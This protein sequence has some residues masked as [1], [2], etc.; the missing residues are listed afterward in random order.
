M[1]TQSLPLPTLSAA[2]TIHVVFVGVPQEAIVIDNIVAE[3]PGVYE[4]R[5]WGRAWIFTPSADGTF[6]MNLR[7]NLTYAFHN[8]SAEFAQGLWGIANDSSRSNGPTSYLQQYDSDSGLNRLASNPEV[9]TIHVSPVERWIIDHRDEYELGFAEPSY[10]VFLLDAYSTGYLPRD[11]YHYWEYPVITWG[12]G[13]KRTDMR[14]WGGN[15]TFMFLDLSAAPSDKE[16]GETAMVD[17]PIWHYGP[18]KETTYGHNGEW[19]DLSA[20]IG[21]DVATFT[22]AQFVKTYIYKPQL[23]PVYVSSTI[24]VLDRSQ[25][26]PDLA[27]RMDFDKILDAMH[28]YMPWVPW[29]GSH[30]VLYLPEDDPG[31]YAAMM[32]ARLRYGGLAYKAKTLI[33]YID[34]HPEK[35]ARGPEGWVQMRMNLFILPRGEGIE[36]PASINGF[37]LPTPDGKSWGTFGWTDDVYEYGTTQQDVEFFLYQVEVHE[38]GHAVGLTHPWNSLINTSSGYVYA[39]SY[40]SDQSYTIM[41]YRMRSFHGDEIDRRSQVRGHT[42]LTLERAVYDLNAGLENLRAMGNSEVPQANAPDFYAASDAI[43][44]THL[45]FGA[46]RWYDAYWQ[47]MEATNLSAIALNG[48]GGLSLEKTT[49]T[50]QGTVTDLGRIQD[51]PYTSRTEFSPYQDYHEVPWDGSVDHLD[52]SVT[53]DNGVRSKANFFAGW[54]FDG[55]LGAVFDQ[56]EQTRFTRGNHEGFTIGWQDSGMREATSIHAGAGLYTSAVAVD[57]TVTIDVYTRP[58]ALGTDPNGPQGR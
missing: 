6:G 42:I 31:M 18:D 1:S 32:E 22:Q 54:S 19:T 17:P 43:R 53:W 58:N 36:I 41:S 34:Q 7:Y 50:W 2:I 16:G 11:A 55:G 37:A 12:P 23:G 20:M 21:V 40:I 8:A 38:V 35:Y 10:T 46:G 49:V 39:D 3:V 9:Q 45:L 26:E 48:S 27:A 4:P 29:D 56:E 25:L 15:S 51:I 5:D 47:A 52:L 24:F 28:Y 14:A 30:K 13:E 44:Q 57:Y 33:N